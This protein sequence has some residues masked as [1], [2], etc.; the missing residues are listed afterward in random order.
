MVKPVAKVAA[1][2]QGTREGKW[3][4]CCLALGPKFERLNFGSSDLPND[5]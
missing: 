2:V 1:Y 3:D 5:L 4:F